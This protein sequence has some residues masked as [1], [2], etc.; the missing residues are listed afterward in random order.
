DYLARFPDR[1]AVLYAAARAYRRRAEGPQPAK[2]P[3]LAREAASRARALYEKLIALR[4]EDP[5]HRGELAD[6]LRA[7]A[8]EEALRFLSGGI[9]RRPR[10]AELLRRRGELFAARKQ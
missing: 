3:A 2:A 4:P 8:P 5:Y 6:F 10:D 1:P 7:T 9:E